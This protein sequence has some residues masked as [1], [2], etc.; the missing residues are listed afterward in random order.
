MRLTHYT[1]YALRTL[2]YLA[3]LPK[4][5]DLATINDIAKAYDIPKN[6]LMKVVHQLSTLGYI[7]SLRGKNGG[8]RLAKSA[9]KI[10]VGE[11]VRQTEP[12]F[13][14][15]ACFETEAKRPCHITPACQLKFMFSEANLAFLSVLDKYSIADTILDQ[16]KMKSLLSF[17]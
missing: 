10:N 2:M 4:H 7:D 5:Q 17:A 12:D 6:H 14:L 3:L 9:D 11:V 16:A 15:V 1:D 13:D 8:I